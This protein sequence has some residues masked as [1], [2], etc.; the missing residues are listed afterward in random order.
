MT[1][2]Q[3]R[4]AVGAEIMPGGAHFR[5][6]APDA[7]RVQVVLE[8]DRFAP[9]PKLWDL[10]EEEGGYWSI[11]IP[12][13]K[14]G[15]CYRFCLNG[16]AN[17][18]PDPASR[19]QP[20]GPHGPSEVVDAGLFQWTDTDWA[21]IAREN[22]VIY[23]MHIGTF[24][25][26]GT[27]RAA[28]EELPELA[29]LGI[30]IIELMPLAEFDGKFGWGYDGVGL[31]APYHHYGSPDDL[32][33]FINQAH[34]LGIG[35]ILDVVYNHCGASGCY[36]RQFSSAYFSEKY[37]GEWGDVF[38]FDGVN[39]DAVRRFIC[40]NA[41][42][43][44]EEFHFDGF[45]LD[46]T[47][48][49][50]DASPRHIIKELVAE[51]RNRAAG[52]QLYIVAENEPQH[53]VLVNPV[54][55]GGYGL[56]AIVND[57]FHHSAMVA[58]KGHREAYFHDYLGRPQ[59]FI[60]AAKYGF[61]YQGQWYAWQ[62]QTRGK[63]AFSVPQ[64]AFIHFLQNHDQV[65]NTGD[66]TRVDA[67][68]HPGLYRA[69]TALCL[70]GPATPMIFQGQEFLSSAPFCYFADHHGDLAEAVAKGRREFLHQ[71]PSLAAPESQQYLHRPDDP[72]T[73][74][75]CKLNFSERDLHAHAYRL[76]RDLLGLRRSDPVFSHAQLASVDGA[77]LSDKAFLL[78]YFSRC[79]TN[80]R[81]LLV[82]M[83]ADLPLTPL[84]EPLVAPHDG[85][86]WQI[87]WSSEH[88]VYGGR[89]TV[90]WQMNAGCILPGCAALVLCPDAVT[91]T[92]DM[93]KK[94]AVA[95]AQP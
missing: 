48:Q 73:F 67:M 65:A 52:R 15:D 13:I 5:L 54:E 33:F 23:E 94:S 19:F 81:L 62:K 42:Y 61:L 20:E 91:F 27:Y 31:F 22:R 36:F 84:P 34:R 59:E 8:S 90:P 41:S 46:A 24:T 32:R 49:I 17:C 93:D 55:Q 21:G 30:T 78:R 7:N 95:L 64:Q 86:G 40:D 4:Y 68:A 29:R 85:C 92:S 28:M 72:T 37:K 39:S 45:R 58:L 3:R 70:L 82:N 88:P 47:Q 56:D 14:A 11:F 74:M 44:I 53:S 6:W 77:V 57:D 66:G 35:V 50:F 25:Q 16:G 51:A 71:F 69:F 2:I 76:H 18:Y 38:N 43:W 10:Q 26:A 87:L 1:I 9:L 89:G 80:D 60:S 83:G 79:G 12:D 75:R 63:L